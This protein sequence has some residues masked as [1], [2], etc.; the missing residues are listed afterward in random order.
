MVE[1]L[2]KK[3]VGKI[4][5]NQYCASCHHTQRIGREGPPLL[6]KFL[7]KYQEKDLAQKIKNGFPQT[8][9]P[10][11]DFLNP[12][13]L[14]Q[15]A[16][17]IKSPIDTHIAW[18]ASNMRDSIVSFNDPL[19]PL[20]IKNKEQILP[21]VERDGNKVWVMEDTR[22][23]SKFHLDNVHGGI[24]YTMDANNIYVPTRD[25]FVQRYS[26]KTGQRMN[27]VRA[28]INLRNISLSRDGSHIFATCLLPE[29]MVVLDAKS[30]LPKKIQKLEGKISAL[31]EF[32]SKDKAI[33]TFRNKPLLAMVDT[34]TFDITYKKIKEP[35]EDFFIDPFE[36]FLI[37]TARRGNI[38]SVYD[39]NKNE[40]VFEHE[41]KGMPHLFSATYWY[42]NGDF[43]FATPHIKKPYVTVWK[44]YDWTFIKK[45]DIQGDGFFVKTHPYTPY[46]WADNGSDKLVLID[47]N[48]FSTK[49]ITPR[50][51]QQYIHTE[52]SGDGKY[53][54][55]SIYEREGAIVILDTQSLKELTAYK[56]N[57][58]VGKYNFINKNR[59]FYPRLFGMDIFKQ[60][61]NNT[62]PCQPENLS[63]YEKKSLFDYLKSMKEG[64]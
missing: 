30:M 7:R 57:M 10:K 49:T 23:L 34:K 41:M 43:Y 62:L 28:C 37:G 50:K 58:P 60:R 47:K 20:A 56:A 5:Y 14:L 12:Y 51:N 52:Y 39:L 21:V 44:M 64:S 17:Y 1:A 26:L 2:P 13:E 32:Y 38:L 63:K 16:R 4:L 8:L 45:V 55:L 53:A 11:F 42:N 61:C 40:Y 3:E 19:S 59:V 54:Y 25:G 33:F 6:P 15:L 24:K 22:I 36:D 18:N 9:M 35:I 31:Y 46:L 27:K 48:D 29:Q